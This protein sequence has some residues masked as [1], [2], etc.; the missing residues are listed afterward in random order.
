MTSGWHDDARRT[1]TALRAGVAATLLLLGSTP[2][3]GA[4]TTLFTVTSF[5]SPPSSLEYQSGFS[6]TIGST[7]TWPAEMGWQGD[8]IDIA[9]TPP[10]PP[11]TARNYRFRVVITQQYTQS[12][13]LAVLAGP[14]LG[15]LVEVHREFVNTPRAYVATIPLATF[16]PGQTNYIR[17]K[18]LGVA[19]GSGQPSGIAWSRWALTR[20][21]AVDDPNAMRAGQLSRLAY[22]VTNAMQP[23]GLVRDS[24]TLNPAD[25]PFHPAT[26]DAGGFALLALCSAHRL[27]LLP[28]AEARVEALLS[29]YSGHTPGVTPARNAKGHWWHWL[30]I[31][32]GAPA[33]GWNDNYTTIGSALLVSGARFAKNYFIQ[34]A[35][36]G[37]YADEM[38][39]SCNFDWMIHPDLGG[40][41]S[42]VSDANGN[43]LGYVNPWNEYMLIVSLALRQPGA[44]RAPAMAWR[45]LDPNAAPKAYYPVGTTKIATLTDSAGNFAP[46]F[47]VHQQHFFNADFAGLAGFETYLRNHARADALYCASTLGQ[48][49]RYG[50]TAG[51]DPTGYFADRINNHHF[52]YAPEAVAGWGDLDGLLEFAADQPPLSNPRFRFGLTRVSSSSPT[53]IPF[54]AGLVDHLFLMFGLVE[55]LDPTFFRRYQAFQPDADD[56]G[57]ADAF[58]NCPNR[59]NPRQQDA[60]ANNV[61]DACDCGPPALDADRDGDVDMFDWALLQRCAAPGAPPNDACLCLD[62]NGDHRIDGG[63]LAAW[64]Q[65][66]DAAGPGRSPPAACD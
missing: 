48:T 49:Y 61:G 7:A 39:L 20:T 5:A 56:D 26:P 64:L 54:D 40:R 25:A 32:T 9:F 55:S 29:A 42:L 30:D 53:W 66:F 23:T 59:W 31:S 13:D 11:A 19:T 1:S 8:Q 18:G 63:D 58:D 15:S 14:S 57:V 33:P 36:I 50:L 51:V 44:T 16:T 43:A 12:F 10:T 34:N 4:V 41:V 37:A 38:W 52:V 17:I 62:R 21:D 45:W 65:C 2:G 27:A 22:Y 3:F 35:T 24:L 47:W 46:A 6:G 60:N 28:D